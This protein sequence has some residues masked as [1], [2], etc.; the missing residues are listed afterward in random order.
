MMVEIRNEHIRGTANVR[1]FGD[2][3]RS[4]IYIVWIYKEEELV[5]HW[6]GTQTG[7]TRQE[8][9]GKLRERSWM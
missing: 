7:A 8:A 9:K 4:Q 2:K 1:H 6:L 5:L 3:V